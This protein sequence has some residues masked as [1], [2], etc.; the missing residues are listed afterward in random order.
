MNFC[1]RKK[2]EISRSCNSIRFARK[3][4]LAKRGVPCLRLFVCG[5]CLHPHQDRSLSLFHDGGYFLTFFAS[6][7]RVR[8]PEQIKNI[9][10][11][12]VAWPY[13]VSSCFFPHFN[14]GLQMFDRVHKTT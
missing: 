12:K 14:F 4:P 1:R 2:T 3:S 6:L 11:I 13:E 5:V 10:V 8:H 7:T 9:L